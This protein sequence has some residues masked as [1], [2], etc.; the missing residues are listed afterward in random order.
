[1]NPTPSQI[2]AMRRTA[3]RELDKRRNFYPKWVKAGKMT[4]GKADF[5]LQAM[6]DIVDYFN[7]LQIRTGPEQQTLF[8]I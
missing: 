6:K 8:Q 7:W 5:E 4:Q 1:M 2:D 3:L